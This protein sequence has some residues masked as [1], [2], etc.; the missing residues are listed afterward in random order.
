MWLIYPQTF[1]VLGYFLPFYFTNSEGKKVN[2]GVL[3]FA[4]R[5]VTRK[6]A[7]GIVVAHVQSG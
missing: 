3:N 1:A 7:T 5:T 2:T 4:L 6:E